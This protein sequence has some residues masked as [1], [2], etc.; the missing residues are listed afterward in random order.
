[1][2]KLELEAV[3]L[4]AVL[5]KQVVRTLLRFGFN[6]FIKQNVSTLLVDL[7][8]LLTVHGFTAVK[9]KKFAKAKQ[10]ASKSGC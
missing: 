2:I 5:F 4:T 1:M 7:N 3:Y 9:R 8:H 10:S 6:T